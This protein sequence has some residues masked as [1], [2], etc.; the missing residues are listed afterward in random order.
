M[1]TFVLIVGIVGLVLLCTSLIVLISA[2][3]MIAKKRSSFRKAITSLIIFLISFGF[4]LALIYMALFMQTFSRYT[5]EEQVGW[6]YA[7]RD[8]GYMKMTFYNEQANRLYW[9]K[10]AGDQWMIE[11]YILRWS[12]FLR[13]LGA[14][15]YYR[16]TRFS[17]RR[18]APSDAPQDIYQ[19]YPEEPI[20][21]FLLVH[22]K[23][24]PLIDAAY[25]IGAF[26]YP[27][28]DTVYIHINDT[29]FILRTD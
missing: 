11:G 1:D 25:G 22:G 13:W 19:L 5:H 10:L 24:I 3:V 4:A 16:V 2:V 18:L 29:G 14:G 28:E 6:L 17:G 27:Q 9:C 23:K 8:E 20:W 21:K 26:Q 15:S 7:Y 12:T